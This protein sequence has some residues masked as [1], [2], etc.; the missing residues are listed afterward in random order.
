MPLKLSVL[1]PVFNEEANLP[2]C[3]KSVRE[4]ADEIFV[5]DS[6]S[7]DKTIEIAKSFGAR[8]VQHEYVNSAAQK[9]WAIPHCTHEWVFIIDADERM[10]PELRAEIKEL[11]ARPNGPEL[12]GYFVVRRNYFLG[13]EIKHGGWETNDVQRLFKRDLGRYAERD[14]H[15]DVEIKD[16]SGNL[17]ES[18]RLKAKLDH[19]TCSLDGLNRYFQR[20]NRYTTQAAERYHREGRKPYIWNFFLH[21]GWEFFKMYILKLGFLDGIPGLAVCSFCAFTRFV[22]YMKLYARIRAGLPPPQA[23][24]KGTTTSRQID[25][26]ADATIADCGLRIADLN[27]SQSGSGIQ[28]GSAS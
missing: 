14:V 23:Y 22:R 17:L 28:K 19:I 3:L 1:V 20:F 6:F 25:G 27:S 24:D 15:A 2:D 18:G 5:V 10:T 21:P 11:L 26:Q 9:N 8:V 7:T 13:G 12:N 4:I 16:A